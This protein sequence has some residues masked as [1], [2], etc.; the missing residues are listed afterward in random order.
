MDASSG[1]SAS[2]PGV[3]R[4]TELRTT[5]PDHGGVTHRLSQPRARRHTPLTLLALAIVTGRLGGQAVLEGVMMRGPQRWTVAVR[6]PDN[7]IAVMV[8]SADAAALHHA[9]AR[10]PIVR[11][12]VVAWEALTLG[13]RALAESAKVVSGEDEAPSRG[14][15]SRA[16]IG[17]TIIVALAVAIALFFLVPLAITRSLLDVRTGASFWLL[18]GGIRAA[19]LIVYLWLLSFVPDMR[20][21]MQYHAAEHMAIHAYESGARIE[22]AS[23]ATQPRHHMRCGTAFLLV[24]MVIAILVFAAV[25]DRTTWVLAVSRIVGIPLIAGLAYEVVR[26]TARH[27]TAV[28]SRLVALPGLALQRLTT[29]TP[30]HEHL[31]VACVALRRLIASDQSMT[32]TE[33]KVEVLA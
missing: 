32:N 29:R 26:V 33:S 11:G 4:P 10:V 18:E 1:S 24:V 21:L 22:P 5:A 3:K 23:V 27:P 14:A 15:V 31:E 8:Q 12:I 7:R 9:L 13:I 16:G 20:R 25:G 30:E 6:R 2:S 28:L 19:V 17:I